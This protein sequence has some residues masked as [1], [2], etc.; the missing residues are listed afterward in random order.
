MMGR[1]TSFHFENGA[2]LAAGLRYRSLA[3]TAAGTLAWWGGLPEERRA[4]PEGWP[5]P[6]QEQAAIER[7]R[8]AG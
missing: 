8:A 4:N 6:A 3:D 7:I 2:S 1:E 5:T